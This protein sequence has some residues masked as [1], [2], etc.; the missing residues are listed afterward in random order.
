MGMSWVISTCQVPGV[1]SWTQGTKP[2]QVLQQLQLDSVPGGASAEPLLFS[3]AICPGHRPNRRKWWEL[4][5]LTLSTILGGLWLYPPLL[6]CVLLSMF[7]P[8]WKC[9][10]GSFPLDSQRTHI[11][12]ASFYVCS[13]DTF[14]HWEVSKDGFRDPHETGLSWLSCADHQ[15]SISLYSPT[16]KGHTDSPEING[17][18]QAY[19]TGPIISL[20]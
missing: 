4:P 12:S 16:P 7:F 20:F 17:I 14:E 5:F 6:A 13:N 18:T 1:Y 8:K 9:S 19:P 2:Y 11:A 10:R 3:E 15:S